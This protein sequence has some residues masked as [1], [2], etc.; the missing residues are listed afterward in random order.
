MACNRGAVG[1]GAF[2]RQ[3]PA[4]YKDGIWCHDNAASTT[5]RTYPAGLEL[6]QTRASLEGLGDLAPFL[7]IRPTGTPPA[8]HESFQ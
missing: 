1:I 6:C 3:L 7:Q 4:S 5:D 2:V 8:D